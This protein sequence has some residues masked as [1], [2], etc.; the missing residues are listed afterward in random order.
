MCVRGHTGQDL[1][2]LCEE[3]A[4]YQS[5][6]PVQHRA[7]DKLSQARHSS[8]ARVMQLALQMTLSGLAEDIS[9]H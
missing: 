5:V 1:V 9:A 7:S 4:Q 8:I 3:T 6:S 2:L